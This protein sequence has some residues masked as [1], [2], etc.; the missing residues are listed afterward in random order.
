[1]TTQID[2]GPPSSSEEQIAAVDLGSNSFHLIVAL[3]RGDRLDV[4]DRLRDPVRLAAGLSEDKFLSNEAFD[5]ALASLD[6]FGQRLRQIPPEN[7]RAVGTNTL[8]SARNGEAFRRRAQTILGH[9]ID[10]I[11]GR[12]EARLI[13][14]GVAHAM[15]RVPGRQLV[16]DI[17]GG[18][19]EFI[20]GEG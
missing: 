3:P 20:I 4:I 10:V 14:L 17:G 1:M 8:R 11:A 9:R 19:T 5:R 13:Y 7:V 2:A 12:E 15:P 16:C 18:S 6:K